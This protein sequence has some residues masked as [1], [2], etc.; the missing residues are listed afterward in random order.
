M[1]TTVDEFMER[2]TPEER[3]KIDRGSRKLISANR[4]LKQLR[5]G[6]DL[7]QEQLAK[8]L[9]ITQASLSEIE[10]RDDALIS[11]VARVVEGVGGRLELYARMPDGTAIPLQ[12]GKSRKRAAA[13]AQG[14]VAVD[15]VPRELFAEAMRIAR[16]KTLN[17]MKANGKKISHYKRS[18]ITAVAR[19]Y[20]EAHPELI[21]EAKQALEARKGAPKPMADNKLRS[22]RLGLE[23]T[24]AN[25]VGR[26]GGGKA[27]PR[28]SEAHA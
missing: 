22:A 10:S 28:R 11:T 13:P 23:V 21:E 12:F 6:M 7:T 2:F 4:T 25:T 1:A 24:A 8:V 16:I 14:V 9:K 15:K 5:K 20:L 18:K 26:R 27:K 17:W 3:A 19:E